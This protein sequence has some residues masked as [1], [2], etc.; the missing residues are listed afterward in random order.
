MKKDIMTIPSSLDNI[1]CEDSALYRG[2]F[3]VTDM[4]NVSGSKLYFQ[5]P[6]DSN[7]DIVDNFTISTQMSSANTVN[8]NHKKV[9]QTLP[10]HLTHNKPFD[11]YPRGRIE[12]SRGCCNG[13]CIATYTSTGTY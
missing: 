7:G 4:N 5:I 13:V 12:I 8:Y 11:Y 9:W 1:L 10:K 2:I 6:C 3:W